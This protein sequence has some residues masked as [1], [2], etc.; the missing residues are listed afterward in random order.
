M[1]VILQRKGVTYSFDTQVF[2]MTLKVT[3][4]RYNGFLPV[5]DEMFSSEDFW[6]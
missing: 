2:V 4:G 1:D 3:N 6:N 5:P